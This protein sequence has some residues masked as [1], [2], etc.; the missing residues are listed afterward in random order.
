MGSIAYAV[1]TPEHGP[2]DQWLV[3]SLGEEWTA[4]FH[5][6]TRDG[7]T[8]EAVI[9]E[10]R[11]VPCRPTLF[12]PEFNRRNSLVRSGRLAV[13]TFPFEAMRRGVTARRVVDALI[14]LAPRGDDELTPPARLAASA[15]RRSAGRPGRPRKFY[16]T[17]AVRYEAIED[18]ERREPGAST[19]AA[20][21]R[22]C[23]VPVTTIAKWIRTA[24]QLGFL[25]A[26]APGQRGGRATTLAKAFS[27]R[28]RK[29]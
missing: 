4:A 5:L 2:D 15:A 1:F 12:T 3:M 27:T 8:A 21:A 18:D 9:T 14:A 19:R 28:G 13:G 6:A 16:A 11:I 10:L 7:A 17:F 22:Q 24:R 26:V 25:T 23:K 20:L 29:S